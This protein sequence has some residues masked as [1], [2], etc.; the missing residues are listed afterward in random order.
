MML[1]KHLFASTLYRPFH[2]ILAVLLLALTFLPAHAQDTYNIEVSPVGLTSIPIALPLPLL[3][4]GLAPQFAQSFRDIILSDLSYAGII[5]VLP[6]QAYIADGHSAEVDYRNWLLIGAEFLVSIEL[7]LDGADI[8]GRLRVHD[9][10]LKREKANVRIR[11][12]FDDHILLAH[13]I[14]GRILWEVS[15]IKGFFNSRIAFVSDRAGDGKQIHVMDFDGR[16][17]L[18]LT[19][20]NSINIIPHWVDEANIAFTS[21]VRQRPEVF[22]RNLTAG[23]TSVLASYGG[24]NTGGIVSPD[25]RYFA[26]TISRDGNS[27]IFLLHRDGRMFKQLTDHRAIDVSPSWSPDGKYIA[28]VSDRSGSPQIYKLNVETLQATRLTF[29]NRYNTSPSWSPDGKKIAFTSLEN[30]VFNIYTVDENGYNPRKLTEGTGHNESPQWSPDSNYL[31][32]TSNR[33]GEY[34]LYIMD[35]TG[36][37]QKRLPDGAGNNA[38]PSWLVFSQ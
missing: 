29:K 4:T 22:V 28:F 2:T 26:V 25:G 14:A 36:T 27:D 21:Y 20:N 10:A 13:E 8:E 33:T 6:E 7:V 23:R 15:G 12:R 11:G 34:K 16:N 17:L 24:T 32:F 3:S 38:M 31:V 30:N 5:S 37:F 18:N 19:R 1:P 35:S 9:M